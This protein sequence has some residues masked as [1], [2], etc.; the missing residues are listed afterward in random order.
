MYLLS[1][2]FRLFVMKLENFVKRATYTRERYMQMSDLSSGMK[3]VE[4]YHRLVNPKS[5]SWF[6]FVRFA[7]NRQ[8]ATNNSNLIQTDSFKILGINLS[9][10]IS[11]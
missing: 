10:L 3:S 9:N 4:S 7:L 2:L 1:I 11:N 5:I 8:A 6:L